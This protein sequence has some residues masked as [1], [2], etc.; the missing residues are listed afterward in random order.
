M[1]RCVQY[2]DPYTNAHLCSGGSYFALKR[3][4]PFSEKSHWIICNEMCN[5]S[6][7]SSSVVFQTCLELMDEE[8]CCHRL[9]SVTRPLFVFIQFPT[10][11][12]LFH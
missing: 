8:F 11:T 4:Q 3:D 10:L 6:N 7:L 12:Y 9:G 1:F 5:T 2:I